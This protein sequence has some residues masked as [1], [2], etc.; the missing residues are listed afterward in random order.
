LVAGASL[1]TLT[2]KPIEL[3]SPN[4]AIL[5]NSNGKQSPTVAA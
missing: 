2:P 1:I 4:P 3:F 5:I